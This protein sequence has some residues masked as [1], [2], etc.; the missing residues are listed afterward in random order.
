MGKYFQAFTFS[1]YDE[2]IQESCNEY[3]PV[4]SNHSPVKQC[5]QPISDRDVTNQD[6]QQSI[7][8]TSNIQDDQSLMN[9]M[10]EYCDECGA[11]FATAMD[12]IRHMKTCTADEAEQRPEDNECFFRYGE[13]SSSD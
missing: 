8:M 4:S 2:N 12:V 7:N 1:G 9:S 5:V 3:P 10:I 13:Q 11:A 6:M